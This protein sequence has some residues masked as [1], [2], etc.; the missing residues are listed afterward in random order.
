MAV[1]AVPDRPARRLRGGS[2]GERHDDLVRAPADPAE[3]V[4]RLGQREGGGLAEQPAQDRQVRGLGQVDADHDVVVAGQDMIGYAPERPQR[5]ERGAPL[6]CRRAARGQLA[7]GEGP[8][9]RAEDEA[10]AAKAGKE[11]ELLGGLAPGERAA[12]PGQAG[13]DLA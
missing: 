13:A 6:A 8:A 2:G 5:G 10:A 1:R 7:G 12:G 4:P 11:G 3:V 9:G